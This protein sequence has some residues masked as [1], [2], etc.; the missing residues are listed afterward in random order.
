MDR[1]FAIIASLALLFV[2]NA[3]D[4][5]SAIGTLTDSRDGQ[6]YR[7][8][9]IGD[10]VWMAENLNFKIEGS[11]CNVDKPDSC[12]NMEGFIRGKQP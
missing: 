3:C 1:S 10:Q 4:S 11:R 5:N 8:V 2:I 12:K 7:I 6:T 9:K